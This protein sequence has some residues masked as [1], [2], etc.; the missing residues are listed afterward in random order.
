MTTITLTPQTWEAT[1]RKGESVPR[2]GRNEFGSI[3]VSKPYDRRQDKIS[4][5]ESERIS[6]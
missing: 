2:R 3:E 5:D 6:T 4:L 1:R